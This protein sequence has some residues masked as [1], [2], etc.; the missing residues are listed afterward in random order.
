MPYTKAQMR[1]TQKYNDKTYDRIEF[2]ISK[3]QKPN[4]QA[5]AAAMGES[6]NG[7]VNRAIRETLERDMDNNAPADSVPSMQLTAE[8]TA[9]IERRRV[10][11]AQMSEQKSKAV[12]EP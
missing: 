6:L 8:E 5:H 1:A 3:G 7:F 11:L 2:K 9:H 12:T 10:T 4:L